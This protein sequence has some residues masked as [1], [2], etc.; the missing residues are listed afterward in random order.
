MYRTGDKPMITTRTAAP[1]DAKALLAIYTPYVE[2]T[3]ITFEYD[4][5]TLEEF[6]SRIQTTLR[7]FPYIIAEEDNE[8]LGYAY[9]SPFKERAAYGWSVETSI[10]VKQNQRQ[11]GI[12]RLLYDRLEEILKKQG[13]LNVNACIGYPQIE[14]EYLTQDSVRFHEK[15]GYSM[16]GTFHKCGYKFGRWYDMVWMEKFIGQHDT[17]GNQSEVIPFP[18]LENNTPF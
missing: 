11:K 1:A 15:L 5:P 16:V 7:K 13:V 6:T 2:Q 9:A 12:G 18:E 10:Y 8:I 14:D 4:V 17:S 3:A